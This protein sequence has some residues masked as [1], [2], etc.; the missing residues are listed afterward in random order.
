MRQAAL[1]HKGERLGPKARPMFDAMF[2]ATPAAAD[3]R[4]EPATVGRSASMS[5][6][7]KCFWTIPSATPSGHEPQAWTVRGSHKQT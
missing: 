6:K 5:G 1:P 4:V 2:A 3:M 7:M